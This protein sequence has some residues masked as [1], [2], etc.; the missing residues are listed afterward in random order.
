MIV[1]E[2]F[3]VEYMGKVLKYLLESDMLGKF[4]LF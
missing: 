4:S 3:G 1:H 2:Q